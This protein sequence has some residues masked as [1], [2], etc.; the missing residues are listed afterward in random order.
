MRN[1][2]YYS[3][4]QR[5]RRRR[6]G[7]EKLP[8]GPPPLSEGTAPAKAARATWARFIM[9]V[10]AADPLLCPDCGGMTRIVA[11]IE[12]QRVVRP[13]LVHHSLCDE[14]RPPP[15]TSGAVP[16]APVELEYLP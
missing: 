14:A 1:Y 16:R 11:F 5:G 12:G 9:K 2:G 8:L 4:V 3:S 13:I 6:Q 15:I 10:F 7:R